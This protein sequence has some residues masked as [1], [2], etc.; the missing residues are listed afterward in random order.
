[1]SLQTTRVTPGY[2]A[3]MG[4]SFK[5]GRDFTEQ[6]DSASARVMIVNE[7]MAK[8]K[9]PGTS[10]IGRTVKYG[11]RYHTVVGVVPTGKYQRLGEPPTPF[12]Y[13]AQA[14]HSSEENSLRFWE[15]CDP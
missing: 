5:Q 9:W 6:D 8:K 7:Q 4:I 12:Y 11:G 14:P 1:M 2:F 15:T 10:P 3:A 13:L